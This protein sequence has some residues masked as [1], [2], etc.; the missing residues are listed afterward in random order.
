MSPFDFTDYTVGDNEQW[1][2]YTSKDKWVRDFCD[3]ICPTPYHGLVKML[4]SD[5]YFMTLGRNSANLNHDW[6]NV[7]IANGGQYKGEAF[8][9]ALL[10]YFIPPQQN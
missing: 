6:Q 1:A 4:N 2:N 8:C 5:W 3:R 10:V 9:G 7:I